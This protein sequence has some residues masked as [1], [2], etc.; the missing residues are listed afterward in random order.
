MY[1]LVGNARDRFCRDAAR[2]SD[3]Q[4]IAVITLKFD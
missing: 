4:Y 3:M 1:N 2:I